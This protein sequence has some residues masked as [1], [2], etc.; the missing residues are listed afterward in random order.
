MVYLF[1]KSTWVLIRLQKLL[2]LKIMQRIL[3]FRL[4]LLPIQLQHRSNQ[5]KLLRN[6]MM[7]TILLLRT[8]LVDLIPPHNMPAQIRP[9]QHLLCAESPCFF[10]RYL[11]DSVVV[12][13]F[14]L[15]CFVGWFGVVDADFAL[16]D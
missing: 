15:D 5:I 3:T 8:L 10:V 9:S 6:I 14:V 4:R 13:V 2:N 7:L 1:E 16:Y 12:A 11:D